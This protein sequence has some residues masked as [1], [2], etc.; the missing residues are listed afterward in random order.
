MVGGAQNGS[1]ADGHLFADA[2]SPPEA[3]TV[4]PGLRAASS[5]MSSVPP[6]A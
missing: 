6:S 5:P 3:S 4:T 2:E 1:G